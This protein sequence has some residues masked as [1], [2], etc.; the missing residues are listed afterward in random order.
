MGH[1]AF[2]T[3]VSNTTHIKEGIFRYHYDD[4]MMHQRSVSSS[5]SAVVL[6]G[7]GTTMRV[8]DYDDIAIEI[9]KARPG[10]ISG[11]MDHAPGNPF[12]LSSRRYAKLVMT[13]ADN[14][15]DLVPICR[16]KKKTTNGS[17]IIQE[18]PL[19]L[20][21]GHSASG[22]ALYSSA[23]PMIQK[24]FIPDGLIGLSPFRITSSMAKISIPSLLW[25]LSTTTCGVTI[26]NAADQAYELSSPD[27]GRV[28]YQLENP[29]G[30]PNHCIFTNHGCPPV[31]P[32]L[33]SDHQFAWVR[34]AVGE[35]VAKFIQAIQTKGWTRESM[36][37]DISAEKRQYVKMF[38][39]EDQVS[40]LPEQTSS[41]A[42][43]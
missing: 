34:S 42:A 9:A 8:E 6:V 40:S 32:S 43:S 2:A 11:V 19:F 13:I 35:S 7:V 18:N 31:C 38:V 10:V 37:L 23:L 39:N 33:S 3:I 28:L 16:Q 4:S 25:G 15:E 5:C 29:Q 27:H 22:E 41:V 26:G 1:Q 20:L 36:E 12:K 14:L 21:G 30:A 24:S 17:L